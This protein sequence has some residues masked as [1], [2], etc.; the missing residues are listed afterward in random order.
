VPQ[1]NGIRRSKDLRARFR[2]FLI[3]TN[4][5]KK[6][7]KSTL[8]KRLSLVVISALTAGMLSVAS[9]PVASAHGAV[10]ADNIVATQGLPNASLFVAT[11]LT[12]TG[13]ITAPS[14]AGAAGTAAGVGVGA[15]SRGLLAKDSSSGTAQTATA[16]AGTVLSLY[17]SVTTATAFTAT[18]GTFSSLYGGAAAANCAA[19]GGLEGH[20]GSA[21]WQTNHGRLACLA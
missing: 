9:A 21:C 15:T 4:E 2:K 6:M 3:L 14:A 12:T 8:R 13:T 5:R 11:K 17:A 1:G 18:G 16:L 19:H 20:R 10:D 7:S